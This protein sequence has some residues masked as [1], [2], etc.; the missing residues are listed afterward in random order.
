MGGMQ[1]LFVEQGFLGT[2]LIGFLKSGAS[3]IDVVEKI[4]A[5]AACIYDFKTRTAV[6][7][8]LQRGQ[9]LIAVATYLGVTTIYVL[10]VWV[11]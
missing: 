5:T 9:Y 2:E 8:L 7:A 10:G 1:Q 4:S 3:K 11:P 6:F